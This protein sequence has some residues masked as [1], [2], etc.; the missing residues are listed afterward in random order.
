M[1]R[2]LWP[3]NVLEQPRS[4]RAEW[5][6]PERDRAAGIGV[7]LAVEQL[8]VEAA[9][10]LFLGPVERREIAHMYSFIKLVRATGVVDPRMRRL[11]QLL[12]QPSS[13]ERNIELAKVFNIKLY[14][15][16]ELLPDTNDAA[17]RIED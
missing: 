2:V 15:P 16:D 3:M 10:S 14:I 11:W 9:Q 7:Y 17:L 6:P 5:L 1:R 13:R 12:G 4:R 8:S